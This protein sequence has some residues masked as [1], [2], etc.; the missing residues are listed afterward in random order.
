MVKKTD[1]KIVKLTK[2][3]LAAKVAT[4]E[5][6]FK[7]DVVLYDGEEEIPFLGRIELSKDTDIL[8]NISSP[9]H[10]RTF[11]VYS[12]ESFYTLEDGILTIHT[13]I[14]SD[15]E[16]KEVEYVFQQT[17]KPLNEDDWSKL[18]KQ[19]VKFSL[20]EQ[21]D[22]KMV[23]MSLNKK[24]LGKISEE[25]ADKKETDSELNEQERNLVEILDKIQEENGEASFS[26]EL[27]TT[28]PD[29]KCKESSTKPV[30]DMLSDDEEILNKMLGE[31]YLEEAHKLMS[32]FVQKF[33]NYSI[34]EYSQGGLDANGGEVFEKLSGENSF[35]IKS[36]KKIRL[37]LDKGSEN[38]LVLEDVCVMR[39]DMFANDNF[40]D[41]STY[42][43]YKYISKLLTFDELVETFV[44]RHV[45]TC[46]ASEQYEN[47]A[48]YFDEEEDEDEYD[49][50]SP[51]DMILF[52]AMVTIL[53]FF[54][55]LAATTL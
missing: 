44:T 37:T 30:R 21:L 42:I 15:I 24:D 36:V 52:G 25:K 9:F 8:F 12:S 35:D 53:I 11:P 41:I 38:R 2:R 23:G 28:V 51:S 49:I 29:F 39:S 47:L 1:K 22:E 10:T 45:D 17:L 14:P 54:C 3:G 16:K 18:I 55:A 34:I 7:R 40:S 26:P 13:T 6:F 43:F 33:I 19:Y 48:A 50:T 32:D 31:T 4:F 5:E 46:I 20:Y 27:I